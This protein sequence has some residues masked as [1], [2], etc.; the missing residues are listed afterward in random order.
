MS[1]PVIK[2]YVANRLA[3]ASPDDLRRD[4]HFSERVAVALHKHG[5]QVHV[6]WKTVPSSPA[7]PGGEPVVY[8]FERE[9]LENSHLLVVLDTGPSTGLGTV[10]EIAR[11]ELV[12][13]IFAHLRSA[14]ATRM[15][16][17]SGL[18]PWVI[19]FDTPEELESKITRLFL[20]IKT[21]LEVRAKWP[22]RQ[23]PPQCSSRIHALRRTVGMSRATLAENLGVPVEYVRDIEL[24]RL[25][26]SLYS[27]RMLANAFGLTTPAPF[28]DAKSNPERESK[29]EERTII[30]NF[31]Y[32]RNEGFADFFHFVESYKNFWHS[33]RPLTETD[34]CNLFR[35]M[36]DRD[37]KSIQIPKI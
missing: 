27:L 8:D 35:L 37:P 23:V 21:I 30:Q 36:F 24:G 9:A 28:I 12:P 25:V 26:P 22:A 4:E 14:P 11:Q 19:E 16:Y 3:G 20:K 34:L 31:F 1:T 13:T 15:I 2:A 7:K 6:A 33:D 10:I 29:S 18:M 32:N 5:C 17:S